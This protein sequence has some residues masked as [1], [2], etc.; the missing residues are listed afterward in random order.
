MKICR[1]LLIAA[2]ALFIA[3]CMSDTPAAFVS[4]YEDCV[5][6]KDIDCVVKN[7]TDH[8][9]QVNGGLTNYKQS[10]PYT[11]NRHS[12]MT[13]EVISAETNDSTATV[14]LKQTHYFSMEGYE[15][16]SEN[17]TWTLKK[18]ASGNWKLDSVQ[19]LKDPN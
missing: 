3:S 13:Y 1:F 18:D 7:G 6:R 17:F 5:N 14:K 12:K 19:P 9:I 4:R 8:L 10:W 15:P 11:F 16:Y 2:F